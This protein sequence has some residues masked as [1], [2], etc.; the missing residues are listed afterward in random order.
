MVRL[1]VFWRKKVGNLVFEFNY[2]ISL[3]NDISL[4]NVSLFVF[5]IYIYCVFY[6]VLLGIV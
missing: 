2:N 3:F 5:F 4:F 1:S 6:D